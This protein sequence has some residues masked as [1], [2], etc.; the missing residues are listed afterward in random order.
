MK[1]KSKYMKRLP[2]LVDT[3]E[4]LKLIRPGVVLG[5]GALRGLF[6]KDEK[7]DDIDIFFTDL[8]QAP[9]VE[10]TLVKKG[11]KVVFKCPLGHLT[12]LKKNGEIKIQLITERQYV[13]PEEMIDTFDIEACRLAYDGKHIYVGS[14]QTI[15]DIRRKQINLWRIDYPNATFKRVIKY[16]A[17]GYK[18]TSE[19][20]DKFTREI[21]SRGNRGEEMNTRFYVD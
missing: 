4:K 18:A 12:T 6:N 13:S 17:K 8:T 9:N 5:G 19:A 20:V 1:L 2:A 7:I 21:W 11:Y 15:R 10:K 3:L 14:R 16:T